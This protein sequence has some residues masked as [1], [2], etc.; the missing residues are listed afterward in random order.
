MR[1]NAVLPFICQHHR[2]ARD[3]T[4]GLSQHFRTDHDM[5]DE[6]ALIRIVVVRKFGQL[7]NLA[8][9]VADRGG[10]QQIPVEDPVCPCEIFAQMNHAQCMLQKPPAEAVVHGLG[11]GMGLER[12]DKCFILHEVIFHCLT[13]IFVGNFLD[14]GEQ[15]LVH[16][17]DIFFGNRHVIRRVVFALSR[18]PE[19]FDVQLEVVVVGDHLAVYLNKILFLVV[20]DSLRI[21]IPHLS[22]KSAGLILQEQVVIRLS[23][24]RLRRTLPP[25]HVNTSD[26]LASA[27]ILNIH[28]L[29]LSSFYINLY[30]YS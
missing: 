9:I 8:D 15:L 21:G 11:C 20:R 5:A 16:H 27:Q 25:A 24:P 6:L 26:R 7:P 13:Q 29:R 23:V 3:G 17:V 22:V 18:L 2:E 30:C 4:D 10:D 1:Q 28:T 19:L 12:L 14:A